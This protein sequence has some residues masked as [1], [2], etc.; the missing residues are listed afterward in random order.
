MYVT[1]NKLT[2][3]IKKR[4]DFIIILN[5]ILHYFAISWFAHLLNQLRL[6]NKAF[7]IPQSHF[8]TFPLSSCIPQLV[9]SER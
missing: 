1:I 2:V 7:V 5:K 3:R 4:R 6:D 9:L 8:D